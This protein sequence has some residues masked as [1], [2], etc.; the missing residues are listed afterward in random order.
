MQIMSYVVSLA[1][2]PCVIG[3]V[4]PVGLPF[5][6]AKYCAGGQ[7]TLVGSHIQMH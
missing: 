5:V 1:T 3:V 4:R 2:I 7:S 6:W